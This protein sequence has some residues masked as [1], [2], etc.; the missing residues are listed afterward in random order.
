MK[1]INFCRINIKKFLFWGRK[2]EANANNMLMNEYYGVTT[3]GTHE[4]ALYVCCQH[5]TIL[6]I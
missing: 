3:Y 5:I 4:G 1:I 6:L 2:K